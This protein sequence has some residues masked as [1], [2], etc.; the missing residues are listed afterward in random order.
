MK[1]TIAQA[2]ESHYAVRDAVRNPATVHHSKKAMRER[3]TDR[4]ISKVIV[5]MGAIY[6]VLIALGIA[7]HYLN[8]I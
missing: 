3:R 8:R 4:Q 2:K 6:L 1:D 7:Y 5:F